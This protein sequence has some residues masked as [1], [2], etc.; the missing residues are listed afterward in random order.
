MATFDGVV[1]DPKYQFTFTAEE[2][3]VLM[4]TLIKFVRWDAS[5]MFGEISESLYGVLGMAGEGVYQGRRRW[6]VEGGFSTVT[7]VER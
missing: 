4:T 1:G 2:I 6:H 5:G 7:E 3:G